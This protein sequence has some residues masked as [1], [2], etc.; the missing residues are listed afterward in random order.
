V[1]WNRLHPDDVAAMVRGAFESMASLKPWRYESRITDHTGAGAWRWVHGSAICQPGPTPDRVQFTGIFT[2]ITEQRQLEEGL[3]Q[4]QR[5]ESIGRLAGGV[6]HDFNNLL[7]A[8]TGEASLLEA[9]LPADGPMPDE[10]AGI[11]SAAESGAAIS[12]LLR[13]SIRLEVRVEPHAGRVRVVV[14]DDDQV[15]RVTAEAL[16][17]FGYDV[18][19]ARGGREAIAMAK[20]SVPPV[21]PLVSDVVMPELSGADV[22]N[23]IR[24]DGQSPRV[25]NVS[26]YPEGAVTQH[27]AAPNGVQLLV[28]PHAVGEPLRR[29]RADLD[30]AA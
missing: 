18:L 29:V 8:I 19:E 28:K 30:H 22:V 6:A 1:V 3:R 21:V 12:R 14:D 20:A 9:D 7:T 24:R 25:L 11:R 5:I 16:R 27:G 10:L 26:G 15:R 17:C 23:A 2:A 4:A 13:E